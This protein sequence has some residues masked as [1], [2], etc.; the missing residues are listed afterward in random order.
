MV[1]EVE[2][3][4]HQEEEPMSQFGTIRSSQEN[5]GRDCADNKEEQRNDD[6]VQDCKVIDRDHKLAQITASK[7]EMYLCD[8][9]KKLA[10]NGPGKKNIEKSV[11]RH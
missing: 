8:I 6:Q 5:H 9:E 7:T 11:S 3:R 4:E 2:E 1:L 10:Q